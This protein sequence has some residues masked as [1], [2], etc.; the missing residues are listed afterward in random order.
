MPEFIPGLDLAERFYREAVKP[1]LDAYF[2]DLRCSAALLGSGSE[3]LGFD[4]PRS[5]DHDWGPRCQLFLEEQTLHD[6]G[7]AIDTM[8]RHQLP[9]RFL[10]YP[11]NFA[12]TE[13]GSTTWMVEVEA[14]PVDHL[15]AL[16]SGHSYFEKYL[17]VDVLV[18]LEPIDW[19]TF[20][21]QKLRAIVYGRIFDD[22]LGILGEI[23]EKLAYYPRDV[24]L[25]LMAAQWQQIGQEESFMGRAGDVGDELGSK[26][27]AARLV[28]YI[29]RLGFLME[30]TYAPYSKWFGTAFEQLCCGPS[31]GPVLRAVLAADGWNEREQ[32]LSKA[33]RLLAEMHN[34]MDLGAP[35]DVDVSGFFDRPYLVIR[36]D[37]FV[38]QLRGMIDDP[39]MQ[40]LPVVGSVNQFVDS[41]DILEWP[42]R[43]RLVGAVYGSL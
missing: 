40:G 12:P 2:P 25:Y 4:T 1:L 32:Y 10:E 14:G 18:S 36:A 13:E 43:C 19:L 29:V 17:G 16:L 30:R 15:V 21:E 7:C 39:W 11:T 23:R 31:L 22:G 41:T 38:E 9:V 27:I 28:Q 33:Y 6:K 42:E 34:E 3:V 37:R 26:L 8:L 24:W 20:S 35:L 5:R